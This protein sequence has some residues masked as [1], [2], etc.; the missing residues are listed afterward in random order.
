MLSLHVYCVVFFFF[1]CIVYG[2]NPIIGVLRPITNLNLNLLFLKMLS[3]CSSEHGISKH[4]VALL[5]A[6]ANFNDRHKDRH[7][8]VGT[9]LECEWDKPKKT[10]EPMEIDKIDI[11]IDQ[12]SKPPMVAISKNYRPVAD[13]HNE[14]QREIEKKCINYV[15]IQV[16]L[17]FKHLILQVMKDTLKMIYLI[18]YWILPFLCKIVNIQ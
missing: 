2:D 4:C 5:I 1:L 13:L 6:L 9:D 12:S 7:T 16:L 3:F 15:K 14:S 8:L 18:Q 10:T 11:R 17:F